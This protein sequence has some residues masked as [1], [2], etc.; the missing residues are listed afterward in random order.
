MN[1]TAHI[2]DADMKASSESAISG[3]YDRSNNVSSQRKIMQNWYM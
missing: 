3:W 1:I 2:D